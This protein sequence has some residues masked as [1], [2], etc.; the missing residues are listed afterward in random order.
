MKLLA[1]LLTLAASL[2]L[3]RAQPAQ[4]AYCPPLICTSSA[5]CGPGCVCLIAPAQGTGSCF[6]I[7]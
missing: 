5:I 1:L 4:C 2:L 3:V 7:Q 6:S